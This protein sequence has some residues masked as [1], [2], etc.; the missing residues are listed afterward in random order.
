PRAIKLISVYKSYNPTTQQTGPLAGTCA[1]TVAQPTCVITGGLAAG[2]NPYFVV[3][4]T[5]GY[6][7][8]GGSQLC[9]AVRGSPFTVNV[10]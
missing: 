4:S 3:D 6:G 8:V 10:P 9:A 5:I 2:D 7:I 1:P